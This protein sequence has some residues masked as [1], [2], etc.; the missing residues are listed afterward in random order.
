MNEVYLLLGSN[1]GE[2]MDYLER[3]TGMISF[4]ASAETKVVDSPVYESE[5]WGF[6]ADRW[7]LNKAVKIRSSLSP[8]VLL[9]R[10]LDIERVL[11]RRRSAGVEGYE[12]REIDIDIIFISDKVLNSEKLSVPHPRVEERR[13][14]L[15]PLCAIAPDFVHPV[16]GKPLKELLLEC[17]DNSLVRTYTAF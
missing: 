9:K 12:S 3:A 11:G 8:E 5:P 6:E 13:F 4:L 2:R 14:V 15:E 16:S 1:K 7:F 17:P 10:V